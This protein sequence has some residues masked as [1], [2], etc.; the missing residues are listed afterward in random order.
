M[1]VKKVE[2]YRDAESG[3]YVTKEY[4]EK[5]KSATVKRQTKN[6]LQR[7]SKKETRLISGFYLLI[8]LLKSIHFTSISMMKN[9]VN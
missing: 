3:E 1:A 2:R 6:L 4:A 8:V 5:H 9:I 7:R